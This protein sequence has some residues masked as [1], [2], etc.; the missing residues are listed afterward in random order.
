M[1]DR[2]WKMEQGGKYRAFPSSIF[3]LPSSCLHS[4][5]LSCSFSRIFSWALFFAAMRLL[6]PP[7]SGCWPLG[8]IFLGAAVRGLSVAPPTS[9]V[10]SPL[11][12]LAGSNLARGSGRETCAVEAG[13]TV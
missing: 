8:W 11:T 10:M 2:G 1:E 4:H 3:H 9:W 7:D 5:W 13:T 12:P 6:M